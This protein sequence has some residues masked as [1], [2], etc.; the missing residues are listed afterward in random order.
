LFSQTKKGVKRKADTTTPIPPMAEDP[1][2]PDFDDGIKDEKLPKIGSGKKMNATANAKITPHKLAS[3]KME[4][5]SG[6]NSVAILS[7]PSGVSA[8]K[9]T[10]QRRESNRQIKKPKRDLP[11][12]VKAE[13]EPIGSVVSQLLSFISLYQG[14]NAK[15]YFILLVYLIEL[16][17]TP[18]SKAPCDQFCL[19]SFET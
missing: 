4:T 12:E 2:E 13:G 5:S 14:V 7:T 6:S 9:I 11:E 1:Y 10:P 3:H 15:V 17:F 16:T 19:P 18:L 8:A